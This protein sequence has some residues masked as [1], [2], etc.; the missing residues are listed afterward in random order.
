M[1]KMEEFGGNEFLKLKYKQIKV[2]MLDEIKQVY[3]AQK[4]DNQEQIIIKEIN[5]LKWDEKERD[6][7]I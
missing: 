5:L 2:L 1:I 6:I 4:K 3:L 7:A